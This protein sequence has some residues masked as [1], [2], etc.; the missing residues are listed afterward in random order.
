MTHRTL[1]AAMTVYRIGDPRGAFPVFSGEG[2]RRVSGRWHRRGQPVIYASEHYSTAM[3]ERLL[4]YSGAMPSGQ[5]FITIAISVGVTY[6][7]A[8]GDSVPGWER[9]DQRASRAFGEQW[10]DERRSAV[11]LVPSVVARMESN[12]LINPAHPEAQRIAPGLERPI[13]WDSRLFA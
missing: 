6:E 11:L 10:I 12:V 1:A 2:A 4:H 8:T 5:H 3:L 13:W 7:V 9:K